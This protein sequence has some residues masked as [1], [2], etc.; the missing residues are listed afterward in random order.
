V[1]EPL[2]FQSRYQLL[3]EICEIL[4]S[5]LPDSELLAGLADRIIESSDADGAV[6]TRFAD[7]G[8]LDIVT[9]RSYRKRD[10]EGA[11]FEVSKTLIQKAFS[12]DTPVF[13][14]NVIDLPSLSKSLRALKVLSVIA[15]PLRQTD[16]AAPFAVLYLDRRRPGHLF[17]QDDMDALADILGLAN[18]TLEIALRARKFDADSEQLPRGGIVGSSKEIST[19]LALVRRA[20]KTDANILIRG[21]TGTGKELVAQ[22]AHELSSFRQ[23]AVRRR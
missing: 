3:R 22:L 1:A 11:E 23:G 21:E 16:A 4:L 9:A 17:C 15:L 5:D 6:L 13:V 20:A 19:L 8:G 18:R 7:D 2:T 14:E 12:E 10:I